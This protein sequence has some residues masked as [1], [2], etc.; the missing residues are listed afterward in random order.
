[1]IPESSGGL[2]IRTF[3]R[4]HPSWTQFRPL[5]HLGEILCDIGVNIE[6]AGQEVAESYC[7]D[8]IV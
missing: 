8:M 2:K 5:G 7:A 3:R 6:R 4:Y 1:M